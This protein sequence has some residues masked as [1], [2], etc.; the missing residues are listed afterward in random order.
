MGRGGRRGHPEDVSISL[1]APPATPPA[2]SSLFAEPL[3]GERR[4]PLL[5]Y[6]P[7]LA[8]GLSPRAAEGLHAYAVAPV[9]QLEPGQWDPARQP[10]RGAGRGMGLLVLDG[11]MTRTV[12]IDDRSA[13]ELVG[14]GDL[15]DPLAGA[16]GVDSL[17]LTTTWRALTPVTLAVLDE[18]F[19]ETA[20]R[21]THLLRALLSRSLERAQNVT[22]QLAITRARRAEDRLRQLFWHMADRWGRVTAA[23][24]VVP[25]RLTHR[26]I[27]ELVGL[28]RP[29]VT[30][31][32]CHLAEQEE[33][34]RRYD[35]T[36]LLAP[37]RRG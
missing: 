18:R 15:V 14:P 11:V 33:L 5:D 12:A 16:E 30:T 31:A 37:R 10:R 2:P 9:L 35:G 27:G 36:W 20:G 23:G 29:S 1:P 8:D 13:C 4:V 34:V 19:V 25:L 26:T 17:D 28:R 24:I 3:A 21:S 22:V 32:L 7:D 6:V